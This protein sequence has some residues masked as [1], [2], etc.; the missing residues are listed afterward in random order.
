MIRGLLFAALLSCLASAAQ[1]DVRRALVIGVA[2]YA[3]LP[4]LPNPVN[5]AHA[6]GGA[7]RS[8][9]Y[10]VI[11]LRDP[12]GT[13]LRSAI[14][15]AEAMAKGAS[16]ALLYYA[17]HAVTFQNQNY[18]FG[19]DADPHDGAELTEQG[20]A[21]TDFTGQTQHAGK[22]LLFIDACRTPMSFP[23]ADLGRGHAKEAGGAETVFEFSAS[24]EQEASDGT[25]EHSPFA[26]ALLHGIAS[27]GLELNPLLV[28]I[29]R[30]V[31]S[32]PGKQ[33]PETH[34]HLDEDFYLVPLP[35]RV[36]PPMASR[37]TPSL[38]T[39][40]GVNVLLAR[41]D[42]ARGSSRL[43][44]L[45]DAL[46]EAP[47]HRGLDASQ[48]L[49][50]MGDIPAPF[51]RRR[52]LSLLLPFVLAPI[53]EPE[54]ERLLTAFDGAPRA[55]ALRVLMPCMA[56]PLPREDVDTIL[57]NV[58]PPERAMFARELRRLAEPDTCPATRS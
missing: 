41:L 52:A 20:V 33:D 53:S 5:D 16:V 12:T 15:N 50:I 7:L 18:L 46:H 38:A 56:R 57:G 29:A 34:G 42:P 1:A 55:E 3:S 49:A 17:G 48:A 2:R 36:A 8:A 13:Q 37:P 11:E 43:S 32:A 51:L 44:L 4:S 26:L 54:A 9:G 6:V 28:Q 58:R 14:W 47:V 22:R 27:P 45:E 10:E 30:E 31:H 39:S 21:L 40:T 35:A 23:S 19:T 25:G 24:V